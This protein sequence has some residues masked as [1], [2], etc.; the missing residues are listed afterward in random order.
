[1]KPMERSILGIV[2]I[3]LAI[4]AAGC[5][6]S[7]E[8]DVAKESAAVTISNDA[9]TFS[10]D[11]PPGEY[12][13]FSLDA[14]CSHD[15]GPDGGFS[16]WTR[17]AY[18]IASRLDCLDCFLPSTVVVGEP[19]DEH[20]ITACLPSEA[21]SG[22][23]ETADVSGLVI[24]DLLAPA[25]LDNGEQ[26]PVDS[27]AVMFFRVHEAW[28]DEL[29]GEYGTTIPFP[30]IDVASTRL[31]VTGGAVV[32]VGAEWSFCDDALNSDSCF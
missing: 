5:D 4:V 32:S 6:E 31:S 8:E 13:G 20:A 28:N 12:T 11:A 3:G 17:A 10:I 30:R 14:S 16:V 24:D 26:A 1:M 18:S 29:E 25:T 9:G 15:E 19:V 7:L 23:D 21:H 2:T 22:C 27:V